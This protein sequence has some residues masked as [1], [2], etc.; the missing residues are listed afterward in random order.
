M[1]LGC[2]RCHAEEEPTALTHQTAGA[3]D[4]TEAGARLRPGWM[5][6]WL[7]APSATHPQARM[8]ALVDAG[9]AEAVAAYL[10]SLDGPAKRGRINRSGRNGE[11]L[12]HARG[13]VACHR[14]EG[15]ADDGRWLLAQATLRAKTTPQALA[16]VIEKPLDLN[17]ES[18]MPDLQLS[19]QEAEAI[20]AFLYG[21]KTPESVAQQVATGDEAIAKRGALLMRERSCSACHEVPDAA[22]GDATS[23]APPLDALANR[24]GGCLAANPAAP[25][26]RYAL[27]ADDRAALRAF[28]GSMDTAESRDAELARRL[29][30]LRCLSCHERDGAGGMPPDVRRAF[31]G[32]VHA[33]APDHVDPP[34]LTGV[35]RRLRSEWIEA[36]LQQ[37]ARARPWM[38][39]R[40][41]HYPEV[42][43]DGLAELLA[44]GASPAP[45]TIPNASL[46][47]LEHGRALIGSGGFSCITCHD[48]AGRP[49]T[50]ARAPDLAQFWRRLRPEWI[51]RW[52]VNPA[53][54]QPTTRM[55]TFFYQGRSAATH[56]LD[57]R[58]DQQ[59]E[60]MLAY[61]AQG[62]RMQPPE[63]LEPPPATVLE[64]SGRPLVWRTILPDVDARSLAIGFPEGLSMVFDLAE[65]RLAYVWQGGFL[66]MRR[67]WTGRGNGP[68]DPVGQRL[69][70]GPDGAMARGEPEP[71]LRFAGYRIGERAVELRFEG[72]GA[73]RLSLECAVV[74][75][76]E[77]GLGL[78]LRANWTGSQPIA[79]RLGE[80][81]E[82][83]P[84]RRAGDQ[85]MARLNGVT[86]AI[87]CYAQATSLVFDEPLGWS[88]TEG[89]PADA[90]LWFPTT[91]DE[92]ALRRCLE[93]PR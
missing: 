63:G 89:A 74:A 48:F 21:G 52:T 83:E 75:R 20:A 46:T 85:A 37:T 10:T 29:E 84:V 17:P 4:L 56:I 58:Q 62:E 55:P 25:L 86:D 41:P 81:L 39:L 15:E 23:P 88:L 24:D 59:I 44:D 79:L 40:M 2:V 35:A 69:L 14:R 53:A 49:A 51:E 6:R 33:D 50:G 12:Y 78:R 5:A 34:N 22:A 61:F 1:E 92:A 80:L 32:H 18:R 13:C 28:L 93:E 57:G 9:E 43:T 72:A 73:A 87:P 8:P 76:A 26:P 70:E 54:V 36:V 65:P 64:P 31:H 67:K 11:E 42:L 60:A 82:G 47:Q 66:D 77:V 38:A 91:T 19:R 71:E 16:D 68:A 27:S 3:P 90:V 45:A 7:A 30:Q